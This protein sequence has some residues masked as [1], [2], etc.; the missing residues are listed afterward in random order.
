MKPEE[1]I[2]RLEGLTLQNAEFK[3]RQHVQ[4]A[5][6]YIRRDGVARGMIATA[7][8][9][10]AFAEHHGQ[11]Q[12]F[13]LTMTL[14]WSRLVAAALAEEG[15]CETDDVLVSL[16]PAL[17]D[18][19]LPLRYYSKAVLFGDEARRRWVEPDLQQLP[20][21]DASPASR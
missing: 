18:K 11:A 10:R 20:S 13:H 9:I 16:H 5:F 4:A 15:S 8:A 3:H 21:F 12:K 14:C 2:A 6:F 7:S 1:L 19:Q 17:M